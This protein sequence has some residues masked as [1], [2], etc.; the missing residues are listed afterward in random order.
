MLL[1]ISVAGTPAAPA[2]DV[3]YLLHKH[4]E[5]VQSEETSFGTTHVFYPEVGVERTTAAMLLDIDPVGLVRG[6]GGDGEGALAQ[7]VNDRPYVASSFLSVAMTRTFATALAGRCSNKPELV[8]KLWDMTITVSVI[9]CRGG[10]AYLRRLFE[11][12]GYTVEA[13]GFP[14]DPTFPEWGESPYFDVTL[15]KFSTLR[16]A[17]VHLYVLIPVL[18][19]EK[20]YYIGQDE[21]EK[22]LRFG[23]GWLADHP[24]KDGITRRYLAHRKHLAVSALE[25]LTETPTAVTDEA[26]DQ[27]EREEESVEK[28]I[29]LG[30]QRMQAVV[31]VL[32]ASE[33]R[34]V[35][36]LGCGG[37]K[38]L[39]ELAADRFFTEIVGLD[40]SVRSLE[41]ASSRLKLEW[42]GDHARK[43]IKLLHGA[44]TYRD[45]RIEGMDGAA[46]VEVIEHLDPPRLDAFARVVFEKS[47]AQVIVVTTPNI[48]YNVRFPTL[49]AGK[50]RHKD[51]RFEWTRHEFRAWAESVAKRFSY[52]FEI[53]GIGPDDADLGS[54]TQ[55]AVFR[56]S[57]GV[58]AES[59]A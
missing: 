41:I 10:E 37:G 13:Q 33:A 55:M 49:P 54:P 24:E 20:H 6:R 16:D 46:A 40:V 19:D 3:G 17:L 39:R 47:A 15:K 2:T 28:T 35:V 58:P 59:V 34:R 31:S 57:S 50:F 14:L 29:S 36:D 43:R 5:R 27:K 52:T 48:E 1:S 51:H 22:L 44:L 7:Y 8:A 9:S 11:P 25:R 45:R 21:V 26:N 23:E 42:L 56:K 18:D 4:P 32:K 12:L 38:L 53:R 30:E